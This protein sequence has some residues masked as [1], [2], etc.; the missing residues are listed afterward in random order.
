MSAG[1]QSF[2]GVLPEAEPTD[3]VSFFIHIKDN[4]DKTSL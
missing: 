4:T 3:K 2:C 1:K